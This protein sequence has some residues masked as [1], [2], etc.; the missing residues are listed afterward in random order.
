VPGGDTRTSHESIR[1]PEGV[2][3]I[4]NEIPGPEFRECCDF[5]KAQ[6]RAQSMA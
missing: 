1:F 4:S 5:T 2:D 6:Q 3:S